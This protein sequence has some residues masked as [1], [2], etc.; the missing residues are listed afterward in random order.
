[1][2][3]PPS[4]GVILVSLYHKA[5]DFASEETGRRGQPV[6]EE[7]KLQ[8]SGL[9]RTVILSGAACGG[10]EGSPLLTRD[11]STSG[12]ALRSG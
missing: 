11:P 6:V 3:A 1:M 9:F 7:D 8:F 12:F 10:V 5:E 4:G 2:A